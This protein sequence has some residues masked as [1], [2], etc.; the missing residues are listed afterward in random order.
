[1]LNLSLG[2]AVCPRPMVSVGFRSGFFS[3]ASWSIK[4]KSVL[5]SYVRLNAF[6][7]LSHVAAGSH[8]CDSA[9]SIRVY[10]APSGRRLISLSFGSWEMID[11]M[12]RLGFRLSLASNGKE[13]SFGSNL[14]WSMPPNAKLPKALG[15]PVSRQFTTLGIVN[16]THCSKL[17]QCSHSLS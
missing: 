4:Y 7:N 15:L 3:R 14:F 6:A 2:S 13:M 17:L 11:C 1:M 5:L 16:C 9:K 12:F 10:T 8:C